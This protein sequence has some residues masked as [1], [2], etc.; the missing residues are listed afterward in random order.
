MFLLSFWVIAH[1]T[2]HFCLDIFKLTCLT[3]LSRGTLVVTGKV[4]TPNNV[5]FMGTSIMV[6]SFF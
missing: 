1:R 5:T 2:Y 3:L 6:Y 4:K